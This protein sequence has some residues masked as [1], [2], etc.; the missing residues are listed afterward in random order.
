MDLLPPWLPIALA[1]ALA[2]GLAAVWFVRRQRSKDDA[3]STRPRALEALDTLASWTPER[4]RIL[5]AGERQAYA[6]LRKALPDHMVLAQ[7]PL[8]RFLRVPTRYSYSEW[9]R[10]VGQLCAD[11][12]V[13]NQHSEVIAVVEVRQPQGQES[14][15][16]MRRHERMDRVLTAA[17]IK[18]HVWREGA[19]PVAAAV[20][21]AVL[22]ADGGLTPDAAATPE[23]LLAS[24]PGGIQRPVA[25]V[26]AAS[27]AA[28][29]AGIAASPD[30]RLPAAPSRSIHDL[31]LPEAVELPPHR[32]PPPSTWFEDLDSAP[33]PLGEEEKIR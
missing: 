17:G 5:T 1:L 3:P 4:S 9:M 25:A 28:V 18:L 12:V 24:R 31:E 33:M 10:R 2:G 23:A 30:V 20:R 22:G 32:E 14:E 27:G 7:V 26:A 8:A 16:G 13:C 19:L 11:I 21:E 6:L 15:R 29:A